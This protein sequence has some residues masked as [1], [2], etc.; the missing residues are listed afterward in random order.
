MKMRR[1]IK[2]YNVIATSK[3]TGV[4]QTGYVYAKNKTEAVLKTRRNDFKDISIIKSSSNL[5]KGVAVEIVEHPSLSEKQA[6][7]I[8]KD[9]LKENLRY[10]SK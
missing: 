2:R 1:Q 4:R 8:V 6:T 5:T 7:Q 9:H 3:L 10:Y